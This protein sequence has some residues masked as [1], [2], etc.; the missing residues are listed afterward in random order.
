[1]GSFRSGGVAIS[2]TDDMPPPAD[3]LPELFERMVDE[4][5]AIPDIYDRAIHFFLVMARTRFF[6]D[7]NKRMGRF[8]MNGVLL[9]H[10]Y[11]RSI[12]RRRDGSNS[13]G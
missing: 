4:A 7:V 10:G 13:I 11:R 9:R 12:F 2:G 5:S 1:M 8:A 6:C 3:S